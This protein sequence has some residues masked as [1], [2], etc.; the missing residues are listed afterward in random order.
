MEIALY[1]E[2]SIL[3]LAFKSDS[4]SLLSLEAG[5]PYTFKVKDDRNLRHHRK[6]FAIVKLF[7]SNMDKPYTTEQVLTWLKIKAGLYKEAKIQGD[8]ILLPDSISFEKMGQKK[9][10]EF[11]EH[12]VQL[13]AG[14]LGISVYSI[15]NGAE[16]YL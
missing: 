1:R 3:R 12:S 10:N 15:E 9:F 16:E 11:Y 14:V 2:N 5:R 7:I 13:M 6:F 8:T 4:D